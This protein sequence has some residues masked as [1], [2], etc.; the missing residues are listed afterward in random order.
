MRLFLGCV[1]TLAVLA[2]AGPVVAEPVARGAEAAGSVIAR[3]VG[4]EVR[5]ID[6]PRWRGVDVRQDLL[7]GDLLRTNALG[8]LA[9][10]FS[11]RTQMRI[12]RN[13]L[14]EVKRVG[15]GGDA[16]FGLQY[17]TIWARAERGGTG[18]TVETPAAS[19]AIRGT[20]WTMTVDA[21]GRTSLVVLEGLV[22]LS[23]AFGSVRVAEGE[24]AVATIGS[25]PTKI[26]IVS[27]DDREQ[28]L[29]HL[30]VRNAFGWMP[31]SPLPTREMRAE[32]A[33]VAATDETRRS[34]E[35]WLT[36]AEAALSLDGKAAALEAAARIRGL[37]LSAA[38]RARLD[39]IDAL[40]AGSEQRHGE[41]A[42][43]FARAAPGLDARRR[44]IALH[45]GYFARSLAYPHR[46]ETPPSVRGGGPYAALAGA[47]ADGFLKDIPAAI[48]TIRRAESEHPDES[49]LPA[50]RA[51]LALLVDDRDQAREAI[52]RALALAP[53]DPT[54]L[55]ARANYRSGLEGDLE[56]A[57]A[58]L[59]RALEVAPGSTTIWN[60]LGLV[61]DS[62]GAHREAEAAFRRAIDLDPHDPVA[63]ANLAILYLDQDRLTEAKAMIDRALAVDPS[64]DVG[65]VAR[66]RYHLQTGETDK[67]M[68]DL[69]AGSTANPA[70]AQGL[71]ML[72]GGY[73]ES[74][75]RDPAEQALKNADRLDPND[76]V[77]A[78]FATA[79]AIDDYDSDRAIR[80]AQE[81]LKRSR[82][83]GG[84]FAA[85]SASRDAGSL[86]NNAFRL[87]GLDAWGRYYGDAVFDPF[88]GSALV[89]QAVSGSPNP[90]ANALGHGGDPVEPTAT[91][92]AFSSLF[93]GLML[94][95]E[96]LSGRSRSAN[97]FRRPFLEG[98]ISAGFT[99]TGRDW[100]WSGEAE[101]QGFTTAPFPVSVYGRLRFD[102]PEEFRERIAPGSETPYV[103][104]GLGGRL[105]GGLAYMTARPTPDDRV[106]TYL[107]I[108]DG[109]ENF[110]DGLILLDIPVLPFDAISYER[111]VK[112]RSA[113]AAAGWSHT[114]GYRNVVNAAIFGADSRQTSAERATLLFSP[115]PV[116][117]RL[118]EAETEQQTYLAAVNHTLGIGDLTLR[119]GVEGGA[120]EQKRSE[121]DIQQ[122]IGFP[123]EVM[124]EER[125][126][127]IRFGRAY[128]DA[129]YDFAPG[130]KGE[131][132]LF[133][134]FI[135][136]DLEL[137]RLEPRIGLAWEPVAGH[138]L[139]AGFLRE[140]S[141]ASTMTLAPIGVLGLQPNQAPLDIGGYADTLAARWDAEWTPDFFTSLDYQHQRLHGLS[142]P[143]P[144]T[145]VPIDAGSGVDTGRIDRVG[146]TANLYLG[147]GFGAFA[148]VAYADSQNRTPGPAH[149]M[150]LPFVPEWS[151][152]AGVTFVHPSNVK[153]TLA[154]THVGRRVG[155][156]SGTVLPA[157]WTLDASLTWEPL[158]K[159]F[160][161]E[162]GA[163]NL[164]DEKFDVATNTPGWG[165]SFAGT[166]KVRF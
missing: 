51:Q 86:L 101:L 44:A 159:R 115:F 46:A 41:A 75:Q 136:G 90:F 153:T 97:L 16:L 23:N 164:L 45:G 118:L 77:T 60:A 150:A 43:L 15:G 129:V 160:A 35:D 135:G 93:Q 71:L 26:V 123:P 116:G 3:K 55:E 166:F 7:A 63:Y 61:Q 69:L 128:V 30:S 103:G 85:L 145:V 21:S 134:S 49:A 96:M 91:P 65:L 151:G 109:K 88:S 142:I 83:R 154:A 18:I 107:E 87:Q 70:Y 148:T 67:A 80:S 140:T 82:A 54:A 146:A 130:L 33:R 163:Y 59:E 122:L 133:G 68:Q 98:S 22:E 37:P 89:D 72:A 143:V 1:A 73:Y 149:G 102:E 84:D 121:R 13:S 5:F 161:L 132:A 152:R 139:R 56:G 50:Y 113:L 114:F 12:G 110:R 31:A 94:S 47:W 99:Q 157:Y 105:A 20:D 138:W 111:T 76:P 74:G 147:G 141:A 117:A 79:I 42:A 48:E 58:D 53:D 125:D 144:G 27:P 156:A 162:L 104:F 112:G 131:A 92:Y 32:R 124:L 28:M 95:P 62:R 155:D 108:Q 158:D 19:A 64:F 81:A 137:Q 29:F 119:Y 126:I 40:V 106:V 11:D 2:G 52:D 8:Q 100:G 6:L 36:L 66:G 10:L 57:R 17:G 25:A 4:E 14:V 127:A 38:Q 39:L 165:R 9:V 78:M 120:L 34:V 24:A